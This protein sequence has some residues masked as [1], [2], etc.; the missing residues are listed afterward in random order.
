MVVDYR[1]EQFVV[2]L[3]IWY[4]NEYNERGEKQLLGYLDYFHQKIGYMLSFNFNKKKA[5]GIK[6]LR[7]ED[8]ILIEAVV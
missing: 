1:G 6:K 3:K 2:E 4:G 8:K 5:V 7:I